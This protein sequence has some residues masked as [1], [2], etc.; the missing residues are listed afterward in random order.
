MKKTTL[1]DV[2]VLL[3]FFA[4]PG[5]TQKVFEQIKQARP[6]SLYLYQDGPRPNNNSDKENIDKCRKIVEE[7]DWDCNVFRFYQ[8]KNVGV[9]PSEFIA[10][11]WFF[12]KEEYGI[13]LEDDDVPSQSFFWYCKELLEKYKNDPRINIICGLNHMGSYENGVEG[14]Y[15]FTSSG[16]ITG[17]ASWKKVIDAWDETYSFLDD[18]SLL[19][20]I[21]GKMGTKRYKQWIKSCFAHRAS[22][23]AHYESIMGAA[24]IL[25]S[26]LNIAPKRNLI[27]NIGIGENASHGT[28]NLKMLPRGIRRIFFQEPQELAFPL[29][30]PSHIIEDLQY[31]KS[32][33]KILG[34]GG[35]FRRLARFSESLFLRVLYGDFRNLFKGLKRRLTLK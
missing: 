2:P 12:E 18:P 20:L 4:R 1:L 3:I 26:R 34:Y 31:R 28:S 19:K 7:V 15:V 23:K 32:V 21:E 8:E 33:E 5:V 16:S 24:A 17:W 13:V 10:Q 9:D 29:K 22:G 35:P 27:S 14:D 30:H 6:R 11:K 25:N